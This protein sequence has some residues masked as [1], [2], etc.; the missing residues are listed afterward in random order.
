M[1][2]LGLPPP[3]GVI[4]TLTITSMRSTMQMQTRT[5]PLPRKDAKGISGSTIQ[6]KVGFRGMWPTGTK[7]PIAP[8]A[9]RMAEVGTRSCGTVMQEREATSGAVRTILRAKARGGHSSVA[10]IPGQQRNGKKTPDHLI[11]T[12]FSDQKNGQKRS[13]Q[14]PHQT[15]S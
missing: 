5:R 4:R 11:Q 2:L 3:A 14:Q 13:G 8:C 9:Q 12:G 7:L 15:R 1:N 6:T 10:E